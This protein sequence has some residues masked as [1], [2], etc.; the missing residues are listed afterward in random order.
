MDD[1]LG[2]SKELTMRCALEGDDPRVAGIK[3][4]QLTTLDAA[5]FVVGDAKGYSWT[6]LKEDC[7][8][9]VWLTQARLEGT[10]QRVLRFQP[11]R[12]AAYHFNL[13]A[14]DSSGRSASC[15]LSVPVEGIGMRVELCWTNSMTTDLD[16][17]LHSP[18]NREPWFTPGL[19]DLSSS[20]NNTTSNN[21]N[22]TASLRVTDRV[23]W[24]YADSPL[25]ACQTPA[26]DGFVAGGRCPNP[27]AS[28]DNNQELSTGT[29]ERTQLDNPRN[30][31][32]FRV[33]AQ[34][35]NNLS[36]RPQVF[37]Y[38]GGER[39]GAFD[40]PAEPL[41]FMTKNPG[42]YGVMWRA[43]DVTTSVDAAGK[44]SCSASPITTNAVTIN[45]LSF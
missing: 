25:S 40:A 28:D 15:D 18:A 14:T 2:E 16:L 34:N 45:D 10:N 12:P 41:G 6:M 42:V 30:G 44:V 38:C 22:A 11:S 19:S 7:D 39:A 5:D 27:R 35:F 23:D 1:E 17:Y 4:D 20:L 9:V 33:M 21:L 37:V 8:A 3:P 26:F 29:T 13:K 24:G 31:D 36:A 32:T 43:A